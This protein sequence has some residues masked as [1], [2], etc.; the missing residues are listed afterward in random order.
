MIADYSGLIQVAEKRRHLNQCM[1][2]NVRLIMIRR[3]HAI[4]LFIYLPPE[5]FAEP[6]TLFFNQQLVSARF[7]D[8]FWGNF[9]PS[10]RIAGQ[11]TLKS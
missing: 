4:I 8:I 11:N 2:L 7:F 6:K 3:V 1:F 10:P 9:T 5:F